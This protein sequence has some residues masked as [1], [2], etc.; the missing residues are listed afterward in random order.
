MNPFK[1]LLLRE[2]MQHHRGWLMLML[3]PMLIALLVLAFGQ[4]QIDGMELDGKLAGH[5][6]GALL[7]S[8]MASAA[9]LGVALAVTGIVAAFQVPGLARR[10]QQ[11][12]SIEFWLSLPV[13]HAQS[14]GATLLM[15]LLLLPWLALGIAL[16]GGQLLAA[17][18]VIKTQGLTAW[19]TMPFGSLLP[20]ILAITLRLVLGTALALLWLAPM[21]L[22]FMAASAWL[23]RWGTPVLIVTVAGFGLWLDK[24]HGNPWVWTTLAEHIASAGKA[25]AVQRDGG[26][27][28]NLKAGDDIELALRNLPGWAFNDGLAAIQAL[29]SPNLLV[30]LALAAACFWLLILRRQRGA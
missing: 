9:S 11:D 15:H 3:A 14:L 29:A 30:G 7:L 22:A 2:W 4:I 24:L 23:K 17:L 26:N 6:P 27:G 28:L 25:L 18:L 12:R 21:I 16:V 1:T 20:A 13:G 19:W 10:D 8:M 5:Q